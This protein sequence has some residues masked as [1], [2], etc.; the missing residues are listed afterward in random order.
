MFAQIMSKHVTTNS[1]QRK[2]G[3]TLFMLMT[4]LVALSYVVLDTIIVPAF[5][6]LEINAAE[7]NLVRAKR[8]INAEL[9]NLAAVTADWSSWDDTYYFAKGENPAFAAI[10]LDTSTML[11]LRLDLMLFYDVE[12]NIRWGR[13]LSD[14]EPDEIS[15]LGIFGID[16]RGADKL[17]NHK[18]LTSRFVGLVH[19]DLGPMLISSLPILRSSEEGPI[20]GTMIMGRLLNENLLAELRARTEVDF[21]VHLATQNNAAL[22]S[23]AQ[24]LIDGKAPG[25]IH[26]TGATEISSFT[27][28]HDLFDDP[29][30][31]L[32]ANMPRQISELGNRTIRG[33]SLMLTIVGFIVALVTW[34][35]LRKMIV[36]PLEL[37]ANRIT[38][39]SRHDSL[40]GL[41]NRD[42]A[43]EC[44]DNEISSA[45]NDNCQLTVLVITLNALTEIA[46]ALGHDVADEYVQ[47]AATQLRSYLASP[48]SLARLETDS[49][50]AILPGV[51][52]NEATDVA[53]QLIANLGTGVALP[54][55]TVTLRPGIGIAVYPD[56]GE[57]HDQLL[58][59][60]TIAVS[61]GNEATQPIAVIRGNE[62]TQP[63]AVYQPG[64]EDRLLRRMTLLQDLHAATQRQELKLYY[65]PK[66]LVADGSVCGAEA[67]VRWDHPTFGWLGPNEFI[68]I[69]EQSG[70]ISILTRWAL[71]ASVRELILW[72][73]DGL[74]L[75]LSVN[76]S[77]Q[78]LLDDD[79][80]WFVN[81]VLAEAN[82]APQN[83]IIEITEEAMV[84]NLTQ[85]R[86]VLR[87]LRELGIKISIDD[88]G[89]GYSSLA[90]LKNLPVDEIKI[91][92]SFMAQLPENAADAAIVK[93]TTD[94]AHNL[95]LEC[96]AEGVES[97]ATFRW[98]RENGI[99]RA[100]GFYF[101]EPLPS[102]NFGRWL[103]EFTGGSTVETRT[104]KL[105][106]PIG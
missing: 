47:Q 4:A 70:K 54:D 76:F 56:H 14:G 61:R 22:I 32:Q 17:L 86:T 94:L 77:A 66:V 96:V 103:R 57:R 55:V 95:G 23:T 38:Y 37:M 26:E 64:D 73:Q 12:K 20:G 35:L 34:L 24:R 99:E 1:M 92:R 42:F 30:I 11:N 36:Q 33:A 6:N 100:Q 75:T 71:A 51:G 68:P 87:Q 19:S 89:T 52:S 48:Y 13:L 69:L 15:K 53:D 40:T 91:D 50:L 8:S 84:R 82:V 106:E 16:T 5:D 88:F 41:Y 44:L 65:Q 43:L 83:L 74:D 31:V 90:Q 60:A 104:L 25:N 105:S 102:E 93:A 39:Q 59:R 29:L 79:L 45:R 28:L 49:F 101:G 46:E 80:P 21:S 9:D 67:L 78:D 98:I 7:T 81:D 18:S 58:H 63:I 72:R 10:N 27:L 97:G 62:A 85:A 3:L 2:V